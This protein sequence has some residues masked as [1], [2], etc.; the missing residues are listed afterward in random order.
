[1]PSLFDVVVRTGGNMQLFCHAL[2][3]VVQFL[4]VLLCQVNQIGLQ[5]AVLFV[6]GNRPPC[7]LVKLRKFYRTLISIP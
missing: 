2:L 1:M 7:G 3:R 4:T 5:C 6:H